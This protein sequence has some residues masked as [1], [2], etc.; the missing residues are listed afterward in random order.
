MTLNGNY[1]NFTILRK[2]CRIDEI[3]INITVHP[4]VW[5]KLTIAQKLFIRL[6]IDY[7]PGVTTTILKI[8]SKTTLPH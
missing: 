5:G 4:S 2:T 3:R 7:F 1:F 8:L 6:C